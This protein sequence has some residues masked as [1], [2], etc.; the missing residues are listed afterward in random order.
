M[1]AIYLPVL[2]E[3]SQFLILVSYLDDCVL[4]LVMVTDYNINQLSLEVI[5]FCDILTTHEY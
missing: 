2:I 4:K 1:I 3:K 5:L